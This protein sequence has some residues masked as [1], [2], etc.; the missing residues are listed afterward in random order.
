MLT[1]EREAAR[2]YYQNALDWA[3]KIRYRPEVALTRFELAEL[4]LAQAEDVKDS[5]AAS[6]STTALR[7]EAQAHL[8]FAIGEFRAMKMKPALQQALRHKGLLTA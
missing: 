6:R 7:S 3:T 4:L 1:G 2:G 8:D 5:N